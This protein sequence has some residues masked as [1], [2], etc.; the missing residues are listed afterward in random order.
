MANIS[1]SVAPGAPIRRPAPGA[2]IIAEVNPGEPLKLDF[3]STDAKFVALD[4]DLV[5]MFG[6]GAKIVL[7]GYAFALVSGEASGADFTDK[8]VSGEQFL[9]A[10]NDMRLIDDNALPAA[11][12][13]ASADGQG[14]DKSKDAE[15][16]PAA[17]EAPPAPPAPPAKMQHDAD[18]DKAPSQGDDNVSA[19]PTV[20]ASAP[21]SS[22]PP[23]RPNNFT[24]NG[25][26]N[27]NGH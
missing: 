11:A 22:S 14:K 27:G 10:L 12:L 15:A 13:T 19:H 20:A 25:N 8:T 26:G 17:E 9:A 3:A 21:D 2:T 4:V 23:S 16:P 1:P 7:P 18:F 6:D 5:V 24:G